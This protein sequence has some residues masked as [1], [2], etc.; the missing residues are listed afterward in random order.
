MKSSSGEKQSEDA[1]IGLKESDTKNEVNGAGEDIT[2]E[3]DSQS[4]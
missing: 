2:S 3:G 4:N 1:D